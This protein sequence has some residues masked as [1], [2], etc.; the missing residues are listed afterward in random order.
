LKGTIGYI[1]PGM[2]ITKSFMCLRHHVLA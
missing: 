2:A 1:A